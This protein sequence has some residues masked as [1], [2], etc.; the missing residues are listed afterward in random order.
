MN[1][2]L[3]IIEDYENETAFRPQKN[4]PKTN[5]ILNA[6]SAFYFIAGK[7]DLRYNMEQKVYFAYLMNLQQNVD[8]TGRWL[9]EQIKRV[10]VNRAIG[11]NCN[12]CPIDGDIDAGTAAG[13]GASKR[14]CL[15]VKSETM[16]FYLGDVLQ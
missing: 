4:K 16:G 12:Y 6:M 10:H 1:V 13:K 14:G 8:R 3:Y 11:C 15:S 9:Y 7:S 2:N 5:P